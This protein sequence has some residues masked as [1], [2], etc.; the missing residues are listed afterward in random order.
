MNGHTLDVRTIA[1]V[2]G[3]DI[4]GRNSVNVPGPG[5]SRADRSL[6]ITISPRAPGGFVVYSHAG[7]DP[8]E[9][10][11]YF[12]GCFGL[13][14]WRPGE[15]SRAPLVATACG[16]DHDRERTRLFSLKLWHQCSDPRGTIVE[17]YLREHRGLDLPDIV[18]GEVIRFHAGLYFDQSTRLPGMVCL[19][20]NIKTNERCGIHR[21]FLDPGTGQKVDRRMLGIAKGAA[22]KFDAEPGTALTI[23]E[24]VETVLSARSAGLGAT[25][26][27][28]S[29][30]AV[31]AFPVIRQLDELTILE[32]N[33]ATSQRDVKACASRY[34]TAGKP[35]NIV[36][37]HVGN[38]F[39]D[40]WKAVRA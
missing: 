15:T 1:A 24:G 9:C 36:V 38:D 32:E 29:S 12:R 13:A 20:R 28:G 26:A 39:N 33:D 19:L 37:P 11:D 4:I 5:H 23:G 17:H 10:R 16:P 2:M 8:I 22:I 21:T 35:V 7:D 31:K 34:L 30:G 3:G 14:P 18:A 40:V 27:L 6:T 25:W